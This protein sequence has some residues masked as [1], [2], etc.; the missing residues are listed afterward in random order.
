MV[1]LS[2]GTS[3]EMSI[4]LAEIAALDLQNSLLTN[5]SRILENRECLIFLGTPGFLT[6]F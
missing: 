5:Y 1:P 2:P 3:T 4:C 6:F